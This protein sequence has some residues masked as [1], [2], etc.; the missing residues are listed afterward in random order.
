MGDGGDASGQGANFQQEEK[1]ER[2]K[3][4]DIS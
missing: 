4:S 2:E 3:A 1:K